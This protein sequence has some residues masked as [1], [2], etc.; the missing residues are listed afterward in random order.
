MAGFFWP[1]Q[2]PNCERCA[3]NC[4]QSTQQHTAQKIS[5]M[6]ASSPK[7]DRRE[8]SVN[9]LDERNKSNSYLRRKTSRIFPNSSY[10]FSSFRST[11]TAKGSMTK[12]STCLEET[13]AIKMEILNRNPAIY[14]RFREKLVGNVYTHWGVSH[15]LAD[16]LDNDLRI[17]E[18]RDDIHSC[19]HEKQNRGGILAYLTGESSRKGTVRALLGVCESSDEHSE[20]GNMGIPSLEITEASDDDDI[21]IEGIRLEF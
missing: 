17:P 16:F 1:K 2:E 8:I 13:Q 9:V 5:I 19:C 15:Y 10:L 3:A 18:I 4:E 7:D 14:N 6:I 21:F 12:N 11:E 20:Y